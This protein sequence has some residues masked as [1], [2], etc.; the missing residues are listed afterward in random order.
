MMQYE[1]FFIE[2]EGSYKLHFFDDKW[3]DDE[4]E[5]EKS[6]KREGTKN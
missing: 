1:K 2:R 3:C 5:L 4:K 6:N